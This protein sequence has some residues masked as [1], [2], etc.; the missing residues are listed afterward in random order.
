MTLWTHVFHEYLCENK[1]SQNRLSLHTRSRQSFFGYKGSKISDHSHFKIFQRIRQFYQRQQIFVWPVTFSISSLLLLMLLLMLLVLLL[2]L[3]YNICRVPRFEPE[4][5]D[6]SATNELQYTYP[7]LK[8][9]KSTYGQRGKDECRHFVWA[10]LI[11][12]RWPLNTSQYLYGGG[13]GGRW[14]KR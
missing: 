1:H 5:A 10:L 13:G 9:A 3:L 11:A 7:Q 8:E 6:R 2:R 14:A 4:T 12:C